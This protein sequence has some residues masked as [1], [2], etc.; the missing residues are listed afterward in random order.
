MTLASTFLLP[1]PVGNDNQDETWRRAP[2]W[3]IL[4]GILTGIVYTCTFGLFWAWFGQYQGIRWIPALAVLML[5]LGLLGYRLLSG[6]AELAASLPSSNQPL[7][8]TIRAML[9]VLF[10]AMIKYA[11]LLSI[12]L[13]I[14]QI[15]PAGAWR[16]ETALTTLGFLYPRPIYRPLILMPMWGRWAMSLAM[17]IGRTAPD[18]APYIKKMS[19]GCS[20][21]IIFAQWLLCATITTVYCAGA[22]EQVARGILISLSLLVVAYLASFALSRWRNGQSEATINTVGLVVEIAFLAL[23]ISISSVIYWY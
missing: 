4:W 1:L 3:L 9:V 13:G 15:T 19:E 2:S 10:V 21:R 18:V 11:L 8:P 5:D 22:G 16:W 17:S 7:G 20:L 12:P 14:W 6:A 23:Y